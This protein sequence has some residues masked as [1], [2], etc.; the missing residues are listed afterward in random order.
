MVKNAILCFIIA[1][2]LSFGVEKLTSSASGSDSG[3]IAQSVTVHTTAPQSVASPEL[4]APAAATPPENNSLSGQEPISTTPQDTVKREVQALTKPSAST[5][6]LLDS[7]GAQSTD[8]EWTIYTI[9]NSSLPLN[10]IKSIAQDKDGVLWVGTYYGGVVRF[11][12]SSWTKFKTK[13]CALPSDLINGIVV[14]D[15]NNK[16]FATG[17][18]VAKYDGEQWLVY[19]TKNSELPS[20]SIICIAAGPN[21][22]ILVGTANNGAARL[23]GSK[24]TPL[25]KGPESGGVLAITVDQNNIPWIGTT[26]IGAGRF[27][28]WKWVYYTSKNSLLPSNTVT[29]FAF[30]KNNISWI[31]TSQG[32]VKSEGTRWSIWNTTNSRLPSTS[33]NAIAVDH[34]STAWLATS[35]GLVQIKG[36]QWKVFKPKNSSIPDTMITT[37]MVD[38]DN[39]LWVGTSKGM[40]RYKN[41]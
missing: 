19:T 23:D 39:A 5:T 25:T 37:L 16:W 29:G 12:G 21:G 17:A 20:N 13:T 6:T 18:G 15:N 1:A 32:I 27:N 41:Q 28:G 40:A 24:W 7:I 31:A 8:K 34:N 9:A 26:G 10:Y 4:T 11:D 30:D 33:I 36:K 3:K 14:D 38:R 2:T 22:G 35:N